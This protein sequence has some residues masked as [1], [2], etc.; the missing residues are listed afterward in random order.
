MK[1]NVSLPVPGHPL[2]GVLLIA[3]TSFLCSCASTSVQQTWTSPKYAGKP[4]GPVAVL[5]VDERGLVRV[6]LENRLARELE[7]RNQKAVRTHKLLSLREIREDEETA[8]A[9]L[10]EAGAESVLI[11]R[12]VAAERQAQSVRVGDERYT[13]VTTGFDPGLPYG[14]YDWYGYYTLA[15]RDMSTVWNSQTK[16]VYLETSLFDLTNGQR[17]WGCLTGTLLTETMDRVAE[18]DALARQVVDALHKDGLIR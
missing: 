17:W 14:A 16:H 3:V 12:L 10:R 5:A 8:V 11:I 7:A 13:P 6:G 18:S 4:I 9:R 2:F 15:F 1:V